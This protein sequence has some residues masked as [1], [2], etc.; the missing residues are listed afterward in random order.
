MITMEE[1]VEER[2]RIAREYTIPVQTVQRLARGQE[3]N[4]VLCLPTKQT[5][6]LPH[7]H[8]HQSVSYLSRRH[9]RNPPPN[10]QP[11]T[12]KLAKAT[13]PT[14]P[15]H[16]L[17]A[18][19]Q[20][21]A[22]YTNTHPPTAATTPPQP[23][24]PTQHAESCSCFARVSLTQR[25]RRARPLV[26]AADQVPLTRQRH[27]FTHLST[28]QDCRKPVDTAARPARFISIGTYNG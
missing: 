23:L 28:E 5:N 8:L 27:R 13:K 22:P 18:A 6:A 4:S 20:R 26:P 17:H 3:S 15:P 10:P 19:H 24:T 21:P 9:N 25:R 1:R 16:R 11:R 14:Q 2:T 12:T 7:H